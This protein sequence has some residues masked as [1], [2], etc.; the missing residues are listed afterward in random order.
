MQVGTIDVVAQ[1]FRPDQVPL[2]RAPEAVFVGRS[3]VGKS[4][5]INRLLGKKNIARVSGTPGKTRGAFFYN[6]NRGKLVVVDLPGYGFAKGARG[7]ER[8][9]WE[10]LTEGVLARE[11]KRAVVQLVDLR[12]E[13]QPIDIEACAWFTERTDEVIVVATKA[14]KISKSK[15]LGMTRALETALGRPVLPISSL[16]GDGIP[17]LWKKIHDS[18]ENENRKTRTAIPTDLP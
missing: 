2:A 6:L 9:L 17:A 7:E 18:L 14:D 8:A 16:T 11:G 3:N 12:L 1:A 10:S 5:L 15:A 4:S 13:P